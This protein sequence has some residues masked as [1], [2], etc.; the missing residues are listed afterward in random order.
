MPAAFQ[1]RPPGSSILT[2]SLARWDIATMAA[3]AKKMLSARVF[4]GGC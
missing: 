1:T 2:H 4:M 3:M